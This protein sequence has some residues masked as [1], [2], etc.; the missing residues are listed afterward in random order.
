VRQGRAL[1]RAVRMCREN[2]DVLRAEFSKKA[3]VSTM[4]VRARQVADNT[5]RRVDALRE[6]AAW[7]E[8]EAFEARCYACGA[9]IGSAGVRA[10]AK[11]AACTGLQGGHGGRCGGAQAR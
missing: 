1:R 6:E 5:R 3:L 4:D 11:R 7:A 2:S 8:C 10:G 9:C